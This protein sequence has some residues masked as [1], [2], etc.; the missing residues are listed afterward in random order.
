MKQVD[1]YFLDTSS[2]VSRDWDLPEFQEA[3]VA[4]LSG[5]RL[6]CSR[7]VRMQ[8]KATLLNALIV[9]HNLLVDSEDPV[10]AL[11]RSDRRMELR[12]AKGRGTPREGKLVRDAGCRLLRMYPSRYRTKEEILDSLQELIEGGWEDLFEHDLGTPLCDETGCARA[13]GAPVRDD[14]GYYEPVNAACNLRQPQDCGIRDFWNRH[15]LDLVALAE[16]DVSDLPPS[17]ARKQMSSIAE[18]AARIQEGESPQGKRCSVDM[19]DAVIAIE[20]RH[21]P[22]PAAVHTLDGDFAPI[23]KALNIDVRVFGSTPPHGSPEVA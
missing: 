16:S 9:L 10:D 4:D 1:A 7:Y 12:R 5:K 19:S 13:A 18:G 2:Q 21:T 20:S 8:Y 23:G 6:Y 3:I 22:E 15:G 11:Q 17:K 14:L